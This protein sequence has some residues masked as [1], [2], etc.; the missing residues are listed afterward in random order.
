MADVNKT[1]A[2]RVEVDSSQATKSAQGTDD[3]VKKVQKSSEA[4]AKASKKASSE[5]AAG[6]KSVQEQAAALPGPIG[7]V[8]SALGGVQTATTAF[9][10]SLGTLRGAIMATGIGALAV[11][12]ASLHE[13][14]TGTERGAQQF[15]VIMATL[16]GLMEGV[17]TVL[18]KIGFALIDLF[19]K[20]TATL[21]EFGQSVK[22]Y[23]IDNFNKILSGAGTL[24]KAMSKLFAGDFNGALETATEGV[25][26]LGDGFLSLNPAT[27][28]V[29]NLAKGVKAVAEESITAAEAFAQLERRMNAVK[30]AERELTVE[31]ARSNKTIAEARLIA[32]DVNR[33]LDERIKAVRKAGA[34]EQQV[35]DKEMQIAR[36][37]L[38]VLEGEKIAGKEEE[39]QIDAI[40]AARA[41]LYELERENIMRRKRLQSEEIGLLREAANAKAAADKAEADR[42]KALADAR[43]KAFQEEFARHQAQLAQLADLQVA[44]IE[45]EQRRE[46]ETARLAFE[47]KIAAIEGEGEIETALRAAL[48]N[49]LEKT[50]TDIEKK[51]SDQRIKKADEEK[52][53]REAKEQELAAARINAAQSTGNALIGIGRIVSSAMADNAEVAKGIATAEVWINAATA[54][55][56]AISKAVQ[57]SATPYDMIANIAVAVGTVAGAIASTISILDQAQIPGGGGGSVGAMPSFTASAPQGAQVS[58]NVTGLVNTQQAELQPIQA[59]VVETQMTGTQGNV[60]QI[61]SQATFGLGG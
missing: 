5:M 44:A 33:S 11:I 22:A 20:P 36:E 35:A 56:A 26:E 16:G 38:S 12:L 37:R 24:G 53:E 7:G 47:R 41:R 48:T 55:A 31:R 18:E 2:I 27:A 25:K 21:R 52:K 34:V 15:R 9:G 13:A 39:V 29:W 61:Y 17:N 59:F 28:I 23:V 30:V 8:A 3:A 4:A 42:L 51:Y 40:A 43:E 58:T 6:L 57:S 49:N 54:T 10:K 50:I 45:D 19:T 32:D 1:V 14:F 60:A 46:E